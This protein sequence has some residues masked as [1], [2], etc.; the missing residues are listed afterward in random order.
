[1]FVDEITEADFAV[2]LRFVADHPAGVC[3]T[4]KGMRI[5]AYS[6]EDLKGDSLLV[7]DIFR[8]DALD[9]EL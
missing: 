9:K 4:P 5:V 3:E 2:V 7:Q 8:F 6:V 1:M